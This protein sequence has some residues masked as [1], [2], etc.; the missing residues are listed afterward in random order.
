MLPDELK[1]LW[2]HDL[3]SKGL[4][5]VAATRNYVIVSD[6]E[7]NDT[8]D[9]FQCLRADTGKEVWTV[10]YPAPGNLDYGNSPRSTPVIGDGRVYLHGAFGHITCVE[11]DTGKAVWD[12]NTTDEFE[13][14]ELPKWGTCSTPLLIGGKLIVNPGAKD[15]SVVALDAKTGKV[16]WKCPGKPAGYGSFIHAKFAGKEQVIG[17]DADSLGGWNPDTGKRLWRLVPERPSDFNVP[18]PIQVGDRLLVTTEN[19]GTR[20]HAFDGEGKIVPKPEAVFRRLAPDTHTPVV[21]AGRVFGVWRR[22]YCLDL[23]AGLKPVWDALDPAFTGYCS[24]VSDGN[25]VLILSLQGE[26]VLLDAAADEFK[27]LGKTRVFEGE[28][29]LYSHPAFLGMRAYVRGSSS[30]VCVELGK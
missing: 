26:F 6:R 11:L 20:L 30:V 17:H 1:V 12:L 16:L 21:A 4:G 10:R 7:L 28:K 2:K 29:G 23:K 5:G 3:I 18:T 13:T 24:A 9:A 8:T 25:R 14:A 19:N 22:L 27:P 15:A